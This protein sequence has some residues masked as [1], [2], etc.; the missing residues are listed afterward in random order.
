MDW[1]RTC[2]QRLR[3]FLSESLVAV[4]D[5]AGQRVAVDPYD[6]ASTSLYL[7]P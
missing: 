7:L 2:R 3:Q 6:L 1:E 4:V 5:F